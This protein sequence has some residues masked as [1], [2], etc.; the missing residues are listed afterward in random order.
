M[1]I[2]T[3]GETIVRVPPVATMKATETARQVPRVR[4]KASSVR[5]ER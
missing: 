1:L 3:I 5:T 4:T 2:G